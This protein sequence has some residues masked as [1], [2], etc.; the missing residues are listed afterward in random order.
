MTGLVLEV[1]RLNGEL[2]DAGNRLTKP[3]G[4]TSARWHVMGAIDLAGSPLT[5]AQIARRMG[6]A[7]SDVRRG[8]DLTSVGYDH[9]FDSPSAFREA[10]ARVFGK[11]PGASRDLPCLLARWLD[12][13]LGAMIAV[14]G[15]DELA[16]LEFVDRRAL[17]TQIA[18]LRRRFRCTI[19]PGNAEHQ[20]LEL[21]FAQTAVQLRPPFVL[22]DA[23]SRFDVVT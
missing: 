18:V 4:L 23:E 7:L 8:R 11:P 19:V 14:A 21:T 13:P 5:V 10:F 9:G 22:A 1:F 17:E 15:K 6:L 12:T 3:F 2:L 20:Y 16:L